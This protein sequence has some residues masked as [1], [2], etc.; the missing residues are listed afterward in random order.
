MLLH[1]TGDVVSGW[2]WTQFV[3]CLENS[4]EFQFFPAESK[5]YG[6]LFLQVVMTRSIILCGAGTG[7]VDSGPHFR[8]LSIA[9]TRLASLFPK[10]RRQVVI[11]VTKSDKLLHEV[12]GG[13]VEALCLREGVPHF[14][15]TCIEL[16]ER[17]LA[18]RCHMEEQ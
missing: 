8:F 5:L 3:A 11:L 18:P 17:T 15:Y 9:N 12:L 14:G 16:V 2:A 7:Q 6:V 1:K 13:W 4:T 10:K